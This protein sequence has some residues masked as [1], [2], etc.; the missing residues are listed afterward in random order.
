[1]GHQHLYLWLSKGEKVAF[2]VVQIKK[3]SY[4]KEPP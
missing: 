2:L 1:M 3:Q 4:V